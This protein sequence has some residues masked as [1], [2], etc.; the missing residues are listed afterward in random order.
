MPI[1]IESAFPYFFPFVFVGLW[2]LVTTVLGVLSG[3]FRLMRAFPNRTDEAWLR[4]RFVSGSLGG[5]SIR[6]ALRLETCASGLRVGMNRILGPFCRDFLV[7][8]NAIHVDRADSFFLGKIAEQEFDRDA[9]RLRLPAYVAD[10]LARSAPGLWP[11]QGVFRPETFPEAVVS[12]L[13]PWA[14]ATC[15][16]ALFFTVVPRLSWDS[17]TY[18]PIAVT[19]LFPAIVFGLAALANLFARTRR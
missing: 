14:A 4:L 17:G 19:V 18:P 3:W 16:A 1:P 10:R 12:V 2:L 15:L 13:K 9:G 6:T 11:E 8:W 5:A 7:P